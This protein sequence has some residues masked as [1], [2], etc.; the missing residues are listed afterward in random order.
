MILRPPGKDRKGTQSSA[1]Q[2]LNVGRSAFNCS[3]CRQMSSRRTKIN[4]HIC[5]NL[6]YMNAVNESMKNLQA[7]YFNAKCVMSHGLLFSKKI[8]NNLE[9]LTSRAEAPGQ[10]SISCHTVHTNCS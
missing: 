8:A 9:P 5:L 6:R 10:F 7:P 1:N 4:V 3:L 2:F